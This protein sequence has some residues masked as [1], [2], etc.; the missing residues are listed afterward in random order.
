MVY[1]ILKKKTLDNVCD[2][3][4]TGTTPDMS[5]LGHPAANNDGEIGPDVSQCL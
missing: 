2:D 5:S 4:L 1:A 3:R